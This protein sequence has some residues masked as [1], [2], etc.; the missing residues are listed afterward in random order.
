MHHNPN[1]T[2][3]GG[4]NAGVLR[5]PSRKYGAPEVSLA[6]DTNASIIVVEHVSSLSSKL[7][8]RHNGTWLTARISTEGAGPDA[9][10]AQGAFITDWASQ[11]AQAAQA[12]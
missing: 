8:I 1:G 9:A 6:I 5:F 10:P 4:R 3:A 2:E 7:T 11:P 12:G